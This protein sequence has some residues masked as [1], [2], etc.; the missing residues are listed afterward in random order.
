MKEEWNYR[1]KMEKKKGY[2]TKYKEKFSVD[3]IKEILESLQSLKVL[4]IGDTIIDEYC[5]VE[6]RGGS[7]KDPMLTVDYLQEEVYAGGILAIANHISNFTEKVTLITLL[8]DRNTYQEFISGK[9]NK[10]V[11]PHFFVKENSPTVSKRRY[12]NNTRNEH[13]KLFMIENI[14]FAPISSHLEEE[15]IVLLEKEMPHYDLVL[16]GD[17]GHGFINQRIVDILEKK[18]KFLAVNVQTNSANLGFNFVTKYNHPSFLSMDGMELRFAV[19]EKSPDYN[20]LIAKLHRLKG[21]SHFL[22]TLGK[23]GVA[24]FNDGNILYC[25]AFVSNVIDV[26]GAGDAIL[27]V[28]SLMS[29]KKTNTELI[30]FIANCVGGVAVGIMG[31]EKSVSKKDILDFVE[32]LYNDNEQEE[33]HNYFAGVNHALGS[34]DKK[35]IQHFVN[36]LLG[37]YHQDKNI[38]VFGNGGSGAT[39]S[40]FC[41]DLVMGVSCGLDKRFKAICLNDNIPAMMAIAN[42]ISFDDIFIEQL[43]NFLKPE[44][45]VIGISG[46]GNS[47]NVVKGLEYAN[48]QGAKTVAICGYKG[49][50]IKDIAQLSVHAEINDMEIAEDVHNLVII[51]CIKRL[52]GKEL[53]NF[54]VGENR[55][56]R[57][58]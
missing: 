53:K 24:Y 31:N 49:G 22:V 39:A 13:E 17:F 3:Q 41:G 42:D 5:F 48:S 30:P 55:L 18:A 38:Y 12:I 45:V 19:G 25:P 44:D 51:H 8:G 32:R 15:V 14:N 4:I 37:A 7:A 33:I 26:V 27:S 11:I 28:A 47:I 52:L 16:V 10:K 40:H 29:C 2:V 1:K 43:K 46:S 6:P 34:M 50:K 9:L 35:N 57:E 54:K 23:E 20:A 56:S 58:N 21:Y 36:I